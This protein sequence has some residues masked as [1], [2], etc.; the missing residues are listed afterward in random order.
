MTTTFLRTCENGFL[1]KNAKAVFSKNF[2]KSTLRIS[3]TFTKKEENWS[4]EGQTMLSNHAHHM[5][6]I[7]PKTL[8]EGKFYYVGSWKMHIDYFGSNINLDPAI[9]ENKLELLANRKLVEI[10][11]TSNGL[12]LKSECL[13]GTIHILK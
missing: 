3:L 13:E 5:H 7:P 6:N 11:V 9:P 10:S 12:L 1:Q 4:L 2:G 8:T